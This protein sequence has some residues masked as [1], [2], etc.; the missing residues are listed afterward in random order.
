M[1]ESESKLKK[2]RKELLQIV[3]E[4]ST[5]YGLPDDEL[6]KRRAELISQVV[7]W[8]PKKILHSTNFSNIVFL[9]AWYE[10]SFSSCDALVVSIGQLN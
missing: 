9:S 7:D 8:G 6:E 4:Y 1:E 2:V 5:L 10:V 3:A